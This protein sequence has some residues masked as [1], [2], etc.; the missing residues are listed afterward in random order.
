MLYYF[1]YFMSFNFV[2]NEVYYLPSAYGELSSL[3]NMSLIFMILYTVLYD[4][5]VICD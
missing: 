1:L 2:L 4:V 3:L 5:F